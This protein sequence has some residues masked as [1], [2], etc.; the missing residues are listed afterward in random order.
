MKRKTFRD[1]LA[2]IYGGAILLMWL[3]VFGLWAMERLGD[4]MPSAVAMVLGAS[5]SEFARIAQ[6]YFRKSGPDTS[7]SP[8]ATKESPGATLPT[9]SP[10]DI[11][12]TKTKC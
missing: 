6:F 8:G 3:S 12:T 9:A 11:D 10:P 7:R 4:N 1:S 2:L 5:V